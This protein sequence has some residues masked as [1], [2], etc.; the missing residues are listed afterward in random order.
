MNLPQ[1]IINK[2]SIIRLVA[3]DVD[4]VMTDGTLY[5]NDS[6]IETKGFNVKDGLGIRSL[7]LND[8]EVAIITARSSETVARRANEL[9]IEHLY[10]GVKNKRRT[11]TQLVKQLDIRMAEVAYMGDDLPDLAIFQNAGLAIAPADA[12]EALL[13]H[14]DL[15]TKA[16]GGRGAVREVADLLLK[17]QGRYSSFVNSYLVQE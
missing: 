14:A 6:G 17:A 8:I 13:E 12:H 1:K 9:K 11:L 16:N 10:Q 2:A 5:F 3:L 4:G 7:M 15:I